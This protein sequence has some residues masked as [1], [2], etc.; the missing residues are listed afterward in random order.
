MLEDAISNAWVNFL[1]FVHLGN[2]TS[3]NLLCTPQLLKC[4]TAM[5]TCAHQY[6]IDGV[7]PVLYG[8]PEMIQIGEIK[9]SILQCQSKNTLKVVKVIHDAMLV[10]SSK[11]NLLVISVTMHLGIEKEKGR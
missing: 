6:N 8:D 11:E 1:H 5:D 9:I 2:K 10:G 4:S 3:Y 7:L